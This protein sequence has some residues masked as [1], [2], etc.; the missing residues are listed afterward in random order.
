MRYTAE[1]LLHRLDE[2]KV[3]P[4][5]VTRLKGLLKLLGNFRSLPGPWGKAWWRLNNLMNQIRSDAKIAEWEAKWKETGETIYVA[6][7][8]SNVASRMKQVT[9]EDLGHSK[10]ATVVRQVLDALSDCMQ[11]TA[12]KGVKYETIVT[13]GS[14][15]STS[16]ERIADLRQ[17]IWNAYLCDFW[18]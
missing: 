5:P 12:E 3:E 7:A 13:L 10:K 17:A 16:W 6:A 14:N 2:L 1:G 18:D 8:L 15:M 9:R 11:A 4:D